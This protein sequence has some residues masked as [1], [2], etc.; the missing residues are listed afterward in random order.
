MSESHDDV[1]GA[2]RRALG[3]GRGAIPVPPAPP[4]IAE[5]VVR[6]VHSAIGLPELFTTRALDNKMDVQTIAA[7]GVAGEI[8]AYLQSR[9]CKRIAL[10]AESALLEKLGVAAALNAAGLEVCRWGALS[11]DAAY[12][13]DA[14][15]T[16]VW[17]AVAETGSLV[18]RPRPEHG[19]AI[20]LVPPI[21]VA[22]VQPKDLVPDLVD[23]F[24]KARAEAPGESIVIISGPSKT[25]DIEM[26]LV[27]GVHGPTEV[28][29][30]IVG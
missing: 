26:N 16:E 27:M 15:V 11:L 29:V 17:C 19:R 7:D 25:S 8:V 20:S 10:P 2:V 18:I 22:V 5:P 3:H 21:H 9:Q 1:I 23:L 30:F 24:E 14:G 13:V 28:A 6:L 4:A 12:D